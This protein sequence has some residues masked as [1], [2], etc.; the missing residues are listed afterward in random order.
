MS[1][2]YVFVFVMTGSVSGIIIDDGTINTIAWWGTTD[3][4]SEL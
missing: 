3:W 1:S 4:L 2:F